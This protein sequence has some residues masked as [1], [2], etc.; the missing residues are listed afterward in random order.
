MAGDQTGRVFIGSGLFLIQGEGHG[1][2]NILGDSNVVPRKGP[3][4]RVSDY[5]PSL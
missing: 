2:T 5:F 1:I 4:S 3:A